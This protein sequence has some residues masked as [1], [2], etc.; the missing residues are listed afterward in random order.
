[1]DTASGG[2]RPYLRHRRV[3]NQ[4][5]SLAIPA[6]R[7]VRKEE[8]RRGYSPSPA[9]GNHASAHHSP[10]PFQRRGC[11]LP[12]NLLGSRKAFTEPV[13]TSDVPWLL[14]DTPESVSVTARCASLVDMT[15][16]DHADGIHLPAIRTSP[17]AAGKGRAHVDPRTPSV[18]S[19]TCRPKPADQ[20]ST[21]NC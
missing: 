17:H 5:P 4:V 13:S 19:R 11:E 1:L 15:L 12:L 21:S 7:V 10:T 6:I 3:L 20:N 18:V 14:T 9:S 16:A 8:G 2:R